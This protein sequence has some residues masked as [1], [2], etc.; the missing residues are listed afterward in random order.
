ML[1]N[2]V[3]VLRAH[4]CDQQSQQGSDLLLV[5]EPL[6][7]V[8]DEGNAGGTQS[9]LDRGEVLAFSKQDRK[10]AGRG[11]SLGDELD[12]ASGDCLRLGDARGSHCGFL[13][14]RIVVFPANASRHGHVQ[15]HV[16]GCV[17]AHADERLEFASLL[18][19]VA[20]NRVHLGDA[21]NRED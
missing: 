5:V 16:T 9:G 17:M 2:A 3:V 4:E 15:F 14:I 1:R 18:P 8:R 19:V 7:T 6:A 11:T 10:V 12:N 13:R 20:A 21:T